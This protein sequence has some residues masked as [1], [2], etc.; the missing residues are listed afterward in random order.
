MFSKLCELELD[1]AID[2]YLR[3]VCGITLPRRPRIVQDI[4]GETFIET[5]ERVLGIAI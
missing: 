4:E 1:Y 2:Q 3:D 5:V